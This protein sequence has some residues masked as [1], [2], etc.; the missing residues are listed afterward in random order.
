MKDFFSEGRPKK[1]QLVEGKEEFDAFIVID[2]E[3]LVY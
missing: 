1:E 2:D 3:F